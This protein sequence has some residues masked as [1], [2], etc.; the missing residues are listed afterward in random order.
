MAK[1]TLSHSLLLFIPAPHVIEKGPEELHP[2]LPDDKIHLQ[3]QAPLSPCFDPEP[4][5]KKQNLDIRIGA[6]AVHIL[7][8]VSN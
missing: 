5:E 1:E 3:L 6:Q 7:V 2:A 4:D 8:G